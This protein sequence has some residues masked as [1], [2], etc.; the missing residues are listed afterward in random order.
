ME[1]TMF[2]DLTQVELYAVDGGKINKK[3]VKKYVDWAMIG[4]GLTPYGCW[5]AAGYAA[6]ELIWGKH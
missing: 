6:G 4:I 1:N 3:E 2:F 5:L